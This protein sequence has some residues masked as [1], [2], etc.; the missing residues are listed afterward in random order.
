MKKNETKYQLVTRFREQLVA[1]R[2]DNYIGSIFYQ[3]FSLK[4]DDELQQELE[5]LYTLYKGTDDYFKGDS[6]DCWFAIW[7]KSI[8]QCN[9]FKDCYKKNSI[10]LVTDDERKEFKFLL[11]KCKD[12]DFSKTEGKADNQLFNETYCRY[13]D[14]HEKIRREGKED[15]IDG[16]LDSM[17]W[18]LIQVDREC[19]LSEVFIRT[20]KVL[21]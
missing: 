19:E 5:Y 21:E 11:H 7:H 20:F 3:L 2:N 8:R 10:A 14:L 18:D 6:I 15:S 17:L 12:K 4:T 9:Y 13:L 16:K 1:W